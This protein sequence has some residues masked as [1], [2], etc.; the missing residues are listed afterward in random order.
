M[1]ADEYADEVDRSMKPAELDKGF[2]TL[3]PLH[4][5]PVSKELPLHFKAAD[6]ARYR[7]PRPIPVGERLPTPTWENDIAPS[8]TFVLACDPRYGWVRAFYDYGW[9]AADLIEAC[10]SV[11]DGQG[12][13]LNALKRIQPTHWLPL[14]PA[15]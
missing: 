11:S 7:W 5:D 13:P 15:P 6:V 3:V 8:F 14:P 9:H 10:D 12:R 4:E 2:K 1:A